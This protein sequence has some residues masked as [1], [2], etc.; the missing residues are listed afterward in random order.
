MSEKKGQK[1]RIG[2]KVVSVILAILL[3]FYVVNQ[4]QLVSGGNS[5]EVPVSYK[6]IPANLT[7]VGPETVM[8]RM[9]GAFQETGPMVVYVDLSGL[10][11]G[12]H[13]VPVH[14]QPVTGAMFTSVQ[15]DKIIVKLENI[16]ERLVNINWEIKQNPPDGYEL[17]EILSSPDTCLVK[18][19]RDI[20]ARVANVVVPVQLG[21]VTGIANLKASL[22]AR[23]AE[24]NLITEG[25]T[26]LP[27][28]VDVYAVVEQKRN[29][30]SIPVS[31]VLL[32][33][34]P[35]GYRLLEVT[36][37]PTEVSVLSLENETEGL[38]EVQTDAITLED[39]TQDFFEMVDLSV[40]PGA[41][42]S[43][44]RVLV[45][46]TIEKIIDEEGQE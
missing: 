45:K 46:V 15:P 22:Q 6:N 44:S 24:G 41:M 13:V 4:G 2:L 14:I 11:I 18:G 34:L 1:K 27:G 8:V 10:D 32:G 28:T 37:D 16:K 23:D 42:V 3:W 43:P 25:I 9:W 33:D 17:M 7:V 12:E 19:E 5:T 31:P 35:E 40:S 38:K 20:V 39:R 30:R 36:S 21:N 26:L 29:V